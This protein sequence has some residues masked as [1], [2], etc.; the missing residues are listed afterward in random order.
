MSSGS[1]GTRG[2]RLK[3]KAPE[4]RSRRRLQ[5]PVTSLQGKTFFIHVR[6][7]VKARE[8][9]KKIKELGGVVEKFLSKD[10]SC[11]VTDQPITS[12]RQTSQKKESTDFAL[13]RLRGQTRAQAML[14]KSVKQEKRAVKSTDV[15]TNAQTWG[16]QVKQVE[17]VLKWIDEQKKRQANAESTCRMCSLRGA[18]LKV[19]DHSREYKPLVKE[20]RVWPRLNLDAPPGFSPFDEPVSMR[21]RSRSSSKSPRRSNRRKITRE[22]TGSEDKKGYCEL[23]D[24]NY[25]GIEK[26]VTSTQ[27]KVTATRRNTYAELD[28]LIG[29]GK[30]LKEFEDEVRSNRM[31]DPSKTTCVTRS[32]TRSRSPVA[33]KSTTDKS[34]GTPTKLSSSPP[35]R[36]TPKRKSETQLSFRG[37]P[38]PPRKPAQTVTPLKVVRF[39][40]NLYSVVKS[41]KKRRRNDNDSDSSHISRSKRKKTDRYRIVEATPT[42]IRLRRSK[43]KRRST[44]KGSLFVSRSP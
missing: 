5:Y 37:T 6:S 23:C 44:A 42:K 36:R 41:T 10:L 17:L 12:L 22:P 20:L 3:D 15:L 19:E 31:G 8:V 27:H 26:H 35:S 24:A 38:S 11:V 30:S 43:R 7:A 34:Q 2:A 39:Q 13:S 9:E 21:T 4:V 40:D 32:R 33:M 14:Q 29:R 16:V 18:F 28:R 25:V 1:K